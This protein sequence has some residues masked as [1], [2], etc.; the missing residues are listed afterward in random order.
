MLIRL[1]VGHLAFP[2][3]SIRPSRTLP[4]FPHFPLHG[5]GASA[6]DC[7]SSLLPRST[8]AAYR[9]IWEEGGFVDDI[10]SPGNLVDR[11]TD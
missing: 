11:F 4:T 1:R 10:G 2:P 3:N 6:L 7:R 8:M 9:G 5:P